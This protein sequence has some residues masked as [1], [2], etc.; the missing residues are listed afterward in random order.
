MQEEVKNSAYHIIDYQGS[1]YYAVGQALVRITEAIIKDQRSVLTISTILHGEY[2]I[3]DVMIS[4][5][6]LVGR[7]GVE[8]VIIGRL[9]DDEHQR[10]KQSAGVIREAIASIESE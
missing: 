4:V 6:C 8:E 3:S 10:L 9:S 2:G 1:T 5:P 7:N